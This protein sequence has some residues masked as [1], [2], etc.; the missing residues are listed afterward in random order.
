M[1]IRLSE[2]AVGSYNPY[3]APESATG[4]LIGKVSGHKKFTDGDEITTT[5]IVAARGRLITT[6]SGTQYLLDGPPKEDYVKFCKD[7]NVVLDL[8]NPIKVI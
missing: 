8:E 7:H 3:Q 1:T 2:W 4:Y 6:H 5:R